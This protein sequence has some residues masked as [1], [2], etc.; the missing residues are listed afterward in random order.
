MNAVRAGVMA[1]ESEE[2]LPLAEQPDAGGGGRAHNHHCRGKQPVMKRQ[3]R[4]C[5]QTADGGLQET[6]ARDVGHKSAAFEER[7]DGIELKSNGRG[8]GVCIPRNP[9]GDRLAA[10][11]MGRKEP[12]ACGKQ[13]DGQ[14]NRCGRIPAYRFLKDRGEPTVRDRIAA[15]VEIRRDGQVG[16]FVARH[17]QNHERKAEL[18]HDLQRHQAAEGVVVALFGAGEKSRDE[19]DC[20]QARRA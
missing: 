6:H 5:Q 12:G 17:L 15:D 13:K 4:P 7:E 3:R 11:L 14:Q 8:D 20:N 19:K 2:Q 9:P 10:L 16:S 18:K 1:K